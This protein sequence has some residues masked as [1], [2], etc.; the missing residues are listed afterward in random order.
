MKNIPPESNRH[1]KDWHDLHA[2]KDLVTDKNHEEAP[3]ASGASVE[4]IASEKGGGSGPQTKDA[5]TT[6]KER[7]K[8]NLLDASRG[9]IELLT[10][11]ENTAPLREENTSGAR[12][13]LVEDMEEAK[14]EVFPKTEEVTEDNHVSPEEERAF[15]DILERGYLNKQEKEP[16]TENL[17]DTK[18]TEIREKIEKTANTIEEKIQDKAYDESLGNELGLAVKDLAERLSGV[19]QRKGAATQEE[20]EKE[21][22]TLWK[23]SS[24]LGTDEWI[25]RF[26]ATKEPETSAQHAPEPTPKPQEAIEE[27][28]PSHEEKK[29]P[30][31]VEALFQKDFA[32]AQEDLKNIV[33]K[34][35]TPEGEK[36]VRFSDLTGGQQLL[37]LENLKDFA[38]DNAKEQALKNFTE[39]EKEKYDNAG[40]IKKAFLSYT[41][42]Y[43]RAADMAQIEKDI[44]EKPELDRG[45]YMEVLREM[46]ETASEAPEA[47][48]KEGKLQVNFIS[49]KDFQNTPNAAEKVKE[50]NDTVARFVGI[51]H[52]W[53]YSK[54]EK[55]QKQYQE[56]KESYAK[57]RTE[58]GWLAYEQEEE[59]GD[60][61]SFV[62]S[63][64]KKV[65]FSQLFTTHPD[66]EKAFSES[67]DK[68][69]WWEGV[70]A[71]A[72]EKGTLMALGRTLSTV[73]A[74][75]AVSVGSGLFA[76]PLA[77]ALA[78]G[79]AGGALS[80]GIIGRYLAGKRTGQ[81]I[82]DKKKL[83]EIGVLDANNEKE[84][85]AAH[86]EKEGVEIG[87]GLADKLEYAAERV[88]GAETAEEKE[89]LLKVLADRMH[90]TEK[91]ISMEVV[92]FGEGAEGFRGR[93]ELLSALAKAQTLFGMSEP[94]TNEKVEKKINELLGT[95]KERIETAE[96]KLKSE[97]MRQGM[98]YGMI[99]GGTFGTLLSSIAYAHAHGEVVTDAQPAIPAPTSSDHTLLETVAPRTSAIPKDTLADEILRKSN[100]AKNYE[101]S[102]DNTTQNIQNTDSLSAE[103][104]PKTAVSVSQIE[105][106]KTSLEEIYKKLG[107]AN[108]KILNEIKN[109][110][111]TYK[112]LITNKPVSST[113]TEI[114]LAHQTAPNTTIKN[115]GTL[116]PEAVKVPESV[117]PQPKMGF[118][119]IQ[120]GTVVPEAVK[121]PENFFQAPEEHLAPNTAGY[122]E[123]FI[124][125]DGWE[126]GPKDVS[127]THEMTETL[128]PRQLSIEHSFQEL[129]RA[130]TVKAGDN[131]WNIIKMKLGGNEDFVKLPPREQNFIIDS[132]KDRVV[133]MSPTEL[134]EMGIKGDPNRI[135]PGDEL[136]LGKV[137]HNSEDLAKIFNRSSGI[138]TAPPPTNALP[139]VHQ[140]TAP[141]T[142][143]EPI[144]LAQN[145][146][147]MTDITPPIH[148]RTTIPEVITPAGGHFEV[149]SMRIQDIPAYGNYKGMVYEEIHLQH[150]E[151]GLPLYDMSMKD[152]LNNTPNGREVLSRIFNMP[153]VKMPDKLPQ[154][155]LNGS[156]L[157]YWTRQVMQHDLNKGLLTHHSNTPA[158]PVQQNMLPHGD[159]TAQNIQ[160]SMARTR[161]NIY[162]SEMGTHMNIDAFSVPRE[163]IPPQYH[164][165]VQ[166]GIAQQYPDMNE[167]MR[168]QIY[169][170]RVVD[171]MAK[172]GYNHTVDSIN[173]MNQLFGIRTP[174]QLSH[175]HSND[176]LE[177]LWARM[178]WRSAQSSGRLPP[179]FPNPYSVYGTVGRFVAPRSGTDL[180][181]GISE[182]STHVNQ[183]VGDAAT[184]ASINRSTGH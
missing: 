73:G 171:M 150:P 119:S 145:E 113:K 19:M 115:E 40:F 175:M 29:T 146:N 180:N 99:L 17:V 164:Q 121:V 51:P 85:R 144:V 41:K 30:P 48:W 68:K 9:H 152:F 138:H 75:V 141:I 50:Y 18:I 173:R 159:Q 181:I 8:E 93:Y 183:S 168:R 151:I 149:F 66:V 34:V 117:L 120:E 14:I 111:E 33:T 91:K 4:F 2:I 7:A 154:E 156:V 37:L 160:E 74:G 47:E 35:E 148:P 124:P 20:T 142:H 26:T 80:G 44:L 110:E 178:A 86:E 108:P 143:E 114:P 128:T 126:F 134:R 176:T 100:F 42:S 174:V 58:I 137:F 155:T 125:K 153:D 59:A 57:V 107:I 127:V 131:V 46:L 92:N 177:S 147:T 43:R 132:I 13:V 21:L 36:T 56:A 84:F 169:D 65:Q 49:E 25:A 101:L 139:V 45:T 53:A 102:A 63:L 77:L 62:A 162:Q 104:T 81:E 22:E 129:G 158:E 166:R 67:K 170:Q 109:L 55:E 182:I 161:E 103:V 23:E 64:D 54:N 82:E 167:E 118:S 78:G 3:L 24:T 52:E 105:A 130:Y 112:N 70:K 133:K 60:A 95:Q 87:I 39:E 12:N 69:A 88:L 83:A 172:D 165:W 11:T 96:E 28:L 6:E 140:A 10:A 136:R 97:K 179:N 89:Q 90:Y 5:S 72:K 32:M 184:R 106:A 1:G 116:I 157:D 16:S 31:E 61:L 76:A 94:E 79:L 98:K 71:I 123:T 38:L 15:A 135:D 122:E 163:Q 27:A